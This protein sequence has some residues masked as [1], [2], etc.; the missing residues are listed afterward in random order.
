MDIFCQYVTE[1]KQGILFM[2]MASK[3]LIEGASKKR[4]RPPGSKGMHGVTKRNV[5]HVQKLFQEHGQEALDVMLSIM[6]DEAV[7]PPVRLKAANDVLK[8]GFGTAVS[9]QVVMQITE[10][11]NQSPVNPAQI[12]R[13]ST[14]E[15]QAVLATLQQFLESESKMVD[16]TPD[17]EIVEK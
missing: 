7:D 2:P 3:E 8:R 4:G 17:A 13:A 15:L 10:S 14:D 9:T 5:Q 11:E 16:V 6:R 12:G 1:Q